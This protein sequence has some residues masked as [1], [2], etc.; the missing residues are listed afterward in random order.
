MFQPQESLLVNIQVLVWIG[1]EPLVLAGLQTT[2]PPRGK[3]NE[4]VRLYEFEFPL[5]EAFL[6]AGF[7][8]LVPR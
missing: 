1:F 2:K 3:L 6:I 4:D 5:H 8:G 7:E